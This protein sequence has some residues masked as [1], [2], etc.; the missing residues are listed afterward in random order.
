MSLEDGFT[1]GELYFTRMRTEVMKGSSTEESVPTPCPH[2]LAQ[3]ILHR[4]Q[5]V[6][7]AMPI[8]SG[9]RRN[10]II[11]MRSSAVRNLLCPMCDQRPTLE[12]IEGTGDGFTRDMVQVCA[13]G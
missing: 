12:E 1:D 7:G 11:W 8:T 4:G 2:T 3:G 13:V 5:H 10:L 9:E 6:H